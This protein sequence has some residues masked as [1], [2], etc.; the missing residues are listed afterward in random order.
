MCGQEAE[1]GVVDEL[2]EILDL[3][4][5]AGIVLVL[6]RVRVGVL[7]AGVCVAEAGRHGVFVDTS[8]SWWLMWGLYSS[9]QHAI[10][11]TSGA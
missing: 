10:G 11:D 3:L 9:C 7:R 8:Y 6:R 2:E 1:L 5:E 4:L